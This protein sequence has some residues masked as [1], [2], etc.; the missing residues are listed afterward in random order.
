MP[1]EAAHAQLRDAQL[2]RESAGL[3]AVITIAVAP[4]EALGRALAERRSGARGA[5]SRS[6]ARPQSDHLAQEVGSH[7]GNPRPGGVSG[8]TFG[9]AVR[10]NIAYAAPSFG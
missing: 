2:D 3:P 6:V 4:D 7:E 5:P 1:Q 9:S 10:S 8:V